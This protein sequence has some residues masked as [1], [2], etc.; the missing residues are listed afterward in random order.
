LWITGDGTLSRSPSAEER[1]VI[2]YRWAERETGDGSA[3]R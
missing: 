1:E 3:A 2:K